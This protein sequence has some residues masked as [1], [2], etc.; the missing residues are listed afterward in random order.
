[1]HVYIYSSL[2]WVCI[3][4]TINLNPRI[5]PKV[6]IIMT[7]HQQTEYIYTLVY[8]NSSGILAKF[9]TYFEPTPG[10]CSKLREYNDSTMPSTL[11]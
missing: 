6:I 7:P 8:T 3:S 4:L 10:V 5:A 2:Y 11:L 9:H 1:M